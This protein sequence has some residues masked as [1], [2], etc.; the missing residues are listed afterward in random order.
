[1]GAGE[2]T[3]FLVAGPHVPA[4]TVGREPAAIRQA[5]ADRMDE[6]MQTVGASIM[7]DHYRMCALSQS[8]IRSVHNQGLLLDDGG[9]PG[10]GVREPPP[11]VLR[12]IIRAGNGVPRCGVE[13]AKQRRV[14]RSIWWL[15]L[16]TG[17]LSSEMHFNPIDHHG[18]THSA[19]RWPLRS[20]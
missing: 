10:C 11:R 9:V 19:S 13:I 5:R 16:R 6:I 14:L 3:G 2:A 4:A 12:P 15:G 1:M 17:A 7:G 8:Q 20:A 18:D